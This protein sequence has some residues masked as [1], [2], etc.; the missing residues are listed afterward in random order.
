MK[1]L[2]LALIFKIFSATSAEDASIELLK[3]AVK[4]Y[5]HFQS[6]IAKTLSSS[7]NNCVLENTTNEK[8]CT[9]K[10]FCQLLN[11]NKD[12]AVLF[13]DANGGKIY[14]PHILIDSEIF[15]GCLKEA[16]SEDI[17]DKK[18]AFIK[19]KKNINLQKLSLLN[20]QLKISVNKNKEASKVEAISQELI[21][22]SILKQQNDQEDIN[23]NK[24]DASKLALLQDIA[25]AEKNLKIKLSKNT[26]DILVEMHQVI[27]KTDY[28][29]ET[30][31]LEEAL[32]PSIQNKN[33]FY[34]WSLLTDEASAGSAINL[35]S[36]RALFS[37][38]SQ[39]AY[40]L[41]TITQNKIVSYLESIKNDNNKN[42][43]ERAIDRVK[44][45]TF[46]PPSLTKTVN[47]VC[48]YP[49]AFYSPTNHS[50]TV[51]PQLLDNPEASLMETM[52]HEIA[53]SFDPC[54]LS[55][56][57]TKKTGPLI[58]EDAPF[59]L[60]IK[61]N[62]TGINYSALD[63]GE[64]IS[65]K[66]AY[67]YPMKFNDNPFSNTLACLKNPTSV[68]AIT[69]DPNV[70]KETLKKSLN[71]LSENGQT[72]I[73]NGKLRYYTYL[74]D[75]LEEFIDYKMGCDLQS[76]QINSGLS[77]L[78]EVFADK[79]ASEI[80]ARD[81]KGKSLKT[82]ENDMLAIV[83]SFPDA[84]ALTNSTDQDLINLAAKY[85]CPHFFENSSENEKIL[86]GLKFLELEKSDP[87]PLDDTRINKILLA[88]PDIKK[89]L[90]C[91]DQETGTKYCE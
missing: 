37:K 58:V 18:A 27:N 41:F 34:N 47:N 77:Q 89:A 8:M 14:N 32:F 59:D 44:T 38:K 6:E 75:H 20:K 84:C 31:D 24:K 54:N 39:D 33:I 5:A 7:N 1:P 46:N 60:D 23:W 71:D 63:L 36:N 80:M 11:S 55:S 26:K 83:A 35:Q 43:I 50:F 86:H 81:L 10:N 79:I 62:Q 91:K 64:P 70:L 19:N 13:Q 28:S 15:R 29:K 85:H 90:G 67:Q 61:M 40:N 9:S 2:I 66:H 82:A 65:M 69:W 30:A 56:A 49:N 57:M 25:Q 68:G 74:N 76:A 12:S 73:N 87:H 51:C 3:N 72:D 48:Q 53:H 16:F 17:A 78:Q 21:N 88:H 42:G 22:I 45:I 52:A 4:D